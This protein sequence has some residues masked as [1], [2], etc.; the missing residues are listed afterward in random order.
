MYCVTPSMSVGFAT[1]SVNALKRPWPGVPPNADGCRSDM[2]K[3]NVSAS[4]SAPA[5]AFVI[6]SG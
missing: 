5:V 6:S 3:R 4:P 1:K 2:S